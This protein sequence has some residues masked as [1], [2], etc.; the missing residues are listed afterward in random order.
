MTVNY[1]PVGSGTGRENFISKAYVVRRLRLGAEHRRGRARAPPRRAAA[2]R[3]A[4]EV[5]VYVSPIAVIYNLDGVDELNLDARDDR[6]DLRRQ[7]HQVERPGDRRA[8]TPTSTCPTPRSPRCTA[9]TTPARPTNF[10]DYLSKAA[11][12]AWTLRRRRHL[13]EQ[14]GEAAEGT[15]G[16]VAAVK[17]GDGTIGYADE[18]QAG[19]LGIAAIKVGD[20]FN[21]PSADGAA[22]GA[23][24][25]RRAPRVAPTSTWRSTIDRTITDSG[26]YPLLLASYL[27]ACQHYDDA[28]EAALVKGF[29][30]L[31]RVATTASRPPPTRPA[32]RRSTPTWPTR[33][34]A[35]STRSPASKRSEA[36]SVR[37]P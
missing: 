11:D 37:T 16:V 36:R 15:S 31:H 4:I 20:E 32:R 9:P 28:N 7:D 1:D 6:H 10:T 26:A 19:G 30:V 21:K 34:R 27:I 25:T 18:S 12:G 29:L 22:A 23:G 35:S 17:G 8:T 24:R 14:G 3:T 13:A 2:A 33:R 5:P